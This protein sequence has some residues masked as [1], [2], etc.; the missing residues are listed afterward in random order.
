MGTDKIMKKIVVF[1]ST[2]SIGK[3]TLEVVRSS[4][5]KFKVM[6]LCAYK[7]TKTL[8][9]QIKEFSPSYVCVVDD[10]AADKLKINLS[11]RKIK[12]FKGQKGLEEFASLRSDISVMGISGIACL[13]ALLI[14]IRHTKR[15]ALANKESIV[16]AGS[17]VFHEAA[18]FKTEIIPV[19]SEI[20][21]LYQLFS[22]KDS[23]FSKVYITAS[24]GA[25]IDYKK[26]DLKNVGIKE[27]LS[28]PNWRMGRRITVDS[29]TLI[30]KGFEVIETHRFF[31]MP[32]ENIGV[33]IHRESQIHALV[34]FKDN[35]VFACCYPPDM[36]TPISFALYYPERC[37]CSSVSGFNKKF[38]LSFEPVNYNK[39]PLFKMILEAAKKDDNSLIIL[40]ACDEIAVDYFLK[41]KIKFTDIYKTM[42]HMFTHYP[43]KKI[44]SVNDI[45]F[46]DDWARKKTQ[47][48]LNK[49]KM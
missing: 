36:R 17:F 1:G 26:K 2:G 4:G 19:D 13:R 32:Y 48:Y 29:A 24:G 6:G 40:N 21:A 16:G 34:E 14:N 43:A 27:V 49:C 8:K 41:N 23:D 25:L 37:V 30:N 11:S 22:K 3:S 20:N 42:N 15:V 10:K 9:S 33:M 47:E 45:F 38:S 7:D 35:T 44:K 39:Y 18:K 46:W 12:L 28:H 5:K 31:N